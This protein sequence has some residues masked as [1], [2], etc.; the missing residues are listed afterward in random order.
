MYA[1]FLTVVCNYNLIFERVKIMSYSETIKNEV[2]NKI[3]AELEKGTKPWNKPWQSSG[4]DSPFNPVTKT[5]Y[6][7]INWVLL[8][9]AKSNSEDADTNLWL[10][11]KGAQSLGGNVKKGSKGTHVVYF[12]IK[13][14]EVEKDGETFE[15]SY[16]MLRNYTVFNSSQI[17]NVDFSKWIKADEQPKEF[18]EL[19]HVENFIAAQKA[20][21]KFGG[22]RA[23]YSPSF[24]EIQLPNKADF[25][26]V[27]DYYATALHELAHWTG[28]KSRLDRLKTNSRF[29][30]ESYAFEELVA[31]LSSAMLCSHN[32]VS[33]DL[34]HA[35]YIDSWLEVLKK[36]NSA[37]FK[38]SALAQ[39]VLEFTTGNAS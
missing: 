9:M 15:Q 4:V 6:K 33:G 26:T 10:T 21:I 28:H 32:K 23:Y 5:S 37:I 38:A 2:T 14:K 35:S 1:K 24:D 36:D 39:K 3:I 11:D 29:G 34:Q 20:M 31:E 27:S 25:K 18:T 12:D 7:G 16:A 13:K 30:T 17:E 19:S 8:S 22:D